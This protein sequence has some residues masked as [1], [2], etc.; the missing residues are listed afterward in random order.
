MQK[1]FGKKHNT[2][3]S[4][5]QSNQPTTVNNIFGNYMLYKFVSKG[6]SIKRIDPQKQISNKLESL[7]YG[8]L[9]LLPDRSISLI[10]LDKFRFTQKPHVIKKY[11][12][13]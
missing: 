5:K 8:Q 11:G 10:K 12:K 4:I 1:M 2:C 3:D 7:T 9:K 6:E 13:Y